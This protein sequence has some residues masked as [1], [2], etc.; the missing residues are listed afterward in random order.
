MVCALINSQMGW[1]G[2]SWPRRTKGHN[3]H[4]MHHA[5]F[6]FV[7]LLTVRQSFTAMTSLFCTI[8]EAGNV[9]PACQFVCE[10]SHNWTHVYSLY[11]KPLRSLSH[12]SHHHNALCYTAQAGKHSQ[13]I[14]SS[15][16]KHTRTSLTC[17]HTQL[18][19]IQHLKKPLNNVSKLNLLSVAGWCW[20]HVASSNS[21]SW[22]SP[23]SNCLRNNCWL[24]IISSMYGETFF[25]HSCTL[26]TSSLLK[27]I[28]AE[29]SPW[30]F[31]HSV[32]LSTHFSFVQTDFFLFTRKISSTP[33]MIYCLCCSSHSPPFPMI[34]VAPSFHSNPT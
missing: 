22:C 20:I 24:I 16:R 15:F 12:F 4:E 3:D 27:L 5:L 21:R 30:P 29:T 6:Y 7:S 11:N 9:L 26:I 1:G 14:N 28:V 10:P 23:P 32:P 19:V 17:L 2:S 31:I 8:L 34:C 13:E 25:K 33:P 18:C